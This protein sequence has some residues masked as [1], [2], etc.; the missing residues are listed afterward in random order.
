MNPFGWLKPLYEV[1]GVPHPKVSLILVICIGAAFSALVWIVA[2]KEVEKDHLNQQK[3]VEQQQ[4]QSTPPPQPVSGSA[5]TTGDNSPAVTGERNEIHI[6]P[7]P[8]RP[9]SHKNSK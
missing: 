4:L 6:E 1:F 8:K 7:E 5:S 3:R 2:G 9:Q